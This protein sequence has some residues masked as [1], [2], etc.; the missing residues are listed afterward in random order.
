MTSV[1]KK[2]KIEIDLLN[3]VLDEFYSTKSYLYAY[4][5]KLR[6]IKETELNVLNEMKLSG[7]YEFTGVNLDGSFDK[8]KVT[9]RHI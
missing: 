4:V 2:L 8:L 6:K 5:F 9:E 1:I 3:N 7:N